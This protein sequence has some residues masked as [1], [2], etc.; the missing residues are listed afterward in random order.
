MLTLWKYLEVSGTFSSGDVYPQAG[1]CRQTSL[2]EDGLYSV[3][4][5]HNCTDTVA[6]IARRYDLD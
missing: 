1:T 6:I 5:L 4:V 3:D 2:A